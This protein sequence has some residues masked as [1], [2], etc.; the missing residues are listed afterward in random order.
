MFEKIMEIEDRFDV[1]STFFFLEESM[2]FNLLRPREWELTL[3][4]YK[5][6]DANITKIMRTLDKQDWEVGLHGS[7]TSYRDQGKLRLEK[8]RLELALGRSVEG[9][10]QHYLNLKIPDTWIIQKK[11]GFLYDASFGLKNMVGFPKGKYRPFIDPQSGMV[12]LPLALMDGYLFR[13]Y[14]HIKDIWKKCLELINEAQQ[15]NAVLSVLWHQRV[16]NEK[17]FPGYSEIYQR[18]ISECLSRGAGF[19]V[20]RQIYEQMQ[21]DAG[22]GTARQM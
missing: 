22:G 1:R 15:N 2:K 7:Y 18:I 14:K 3:G 6:S 12:V 16:F 21:A 13:I 8:E 20:G 9:I 5:F 19:R 4:K 11:A 10:R 17:E